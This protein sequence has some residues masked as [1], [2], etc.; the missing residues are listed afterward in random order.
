MDS[1]TSPIAYVQC[2][3]AARTRRQPFKRYWPSPFQ[4]PLF[5]IRFQRTARGSGTAA[6][7]HEMGQQTQGKALD[8]TV[9]PINGAP[10]NGE[11]DNTTT[12]PSRPK[13]ASLLSSKESMPPLG[14]TLTG[15]QEHCM[16]PHSLP[17]MECSFGVSIDP[18]ADQR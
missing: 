4:P 15:K 6:G 5:N 2:L 14:A 3:S 17:T 8:G 9:Q 11:S 12:F 13:P 7:T 16:T 10:I 18:E 1:A